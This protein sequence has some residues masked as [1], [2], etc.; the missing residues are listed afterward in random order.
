MLIKQTA[1][2]DPDTLSILRR[3]SEARGCNRQ[4]LIREAIKAHLRKMKRRKAPT[5]KPAST[6]R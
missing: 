2:F 1:Y 3:M 4:V 5:A 6:A